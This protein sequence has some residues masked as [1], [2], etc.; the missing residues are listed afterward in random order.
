MSKVREISESSEW[1]RVSSHSHITGLDDGLIGQ[2]EAREAA[3][4]VVN[5]VKEG[6]FGGR[7]VLI[8]GPPGSGKTALAL[9]ISKELGSDV[10]FV[11]LTGSEVYSS[12]VK[13][14]EF[15][16]QSLRKAI[17]VR[18][19]ELR[20][21]YEGVVESVEIKQEPHPFN[22]YQQLT[23]AKIK[24]KSSKE[25]KTLSLDHGFTQQL[26]QQGIE[27]GDVVQID[28]DGERLIKVGSVEGKK[29]FDLRSGGSKVVPMPSGPIYK[30]KEFVYTLTLHQMDLINSRSGGSLIDLFFGGSGA[31]I[32]SELRKRIDDQVKRMVEE[33]K[34]QIIP[35]VLF[36]DEC[37][38]LDIE[39][40]AFLNRAMESELAPIIIFATNRGVTRIKGTD[41]K[42]P[43]G[44][45]VDLLDRLLIITTKK[46]SSEEVKRILELRAEKEGINVD[47]S[48]LNYLTTI[49]VEK[50]LRYA[51]QLLAP[52]NQI[53]GG[54]KVKKGDVEK[55]EKLFVDV[56]RSVNYLQEFEEEMLHQ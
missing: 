3:R 15:L 29:S 36:I 17:G 45:P 32:D 9:A 56:K 50:S 43:H 51:I 4:I 16:T 20:N 31:E 33:G 34:A 14:T 55:A 40:F 52:S 8:A 41:L 1:E 48:A 12:N 21:I 23:I 28:P 49:G 47:S 26:I 25:S 30:E 10:P 27:K 11:P 53:A 44:M 19:T 5:L 39:T 18:I 7:S 38:L 2:D 42:S 37:S 54:S 46:Y 35:G 6:K 13:K 22:P 24:L